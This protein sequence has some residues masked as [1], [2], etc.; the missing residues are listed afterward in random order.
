MQLKR[1]GNTGLKVSEIALG[2]L[3]FGGTCD[4]A[5]AIAIVDAYLEAGG[6]F[7]DTANAYGIGASETVLGRALKGRRH[8]VAL[9]TKVCSPMGPGPFERGLSRRHIMQAIDDSLRRLQTDYVDLYQ[10][11]RWDTDTPIEETLRALDD[12]V[13][14]GKVR[15]IGCSNVTGWQLSLALGVSERDRLASFVSL[16]PEYSLVRR[17]IERE[18]VSACRY[19]DVAI[20]PWSPLGAGLLT[21]K[22]S[23]GEPPPPGSKGEFLLRGQHA[24][25]WKSKFT[26]RSFAIIDIV[27]SIAAEQGIS[28]AQVAL[29]WVMDQPGI[30][31]P[32]IG[33]SSVEQL[34][35]NLSAADVHLEDEQM[36]RLTINSAIDL[37]Y[38][39]GFKQ[40]A[41]R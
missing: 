4:D 30:T 16:Q 18:L 41:D 11:H 1:L 22:Y 25:N 15:Y 37:G 32:I 33:V 31:A 9:A 7:F 14:A 20:I 21:G 10:I 27:R 34:R 40:L 23:L 8:E 39:Y 28:M 2:T 36:E 5:T 24:G 26:E 6:N 12:C 19:H 29:R 3:P 13:K 38:P 17:D 35:D